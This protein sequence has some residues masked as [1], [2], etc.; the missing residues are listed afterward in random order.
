MD[1]FGLPLCFSR[2]R[3]QD[4][5]Q[6][7]LRL[8]KGTG[9]GWC[10]T[11][12]A[13]LVDR[14][15]SATMAHVCVLQLFPDALFATIKP[16]ITRRLRRELRFFVEDRNLNTLNAYSFHHK[17]FKLCGIAARPSR[18]IGSASRPTRCTYPRRAFRP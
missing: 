4:G 12:K 9:A 14:L 2:R 11:T 3:L 8:T 13:C 15:E 5:R 18:M 7:L 16:S 1:R 17:N 6:L 10:D